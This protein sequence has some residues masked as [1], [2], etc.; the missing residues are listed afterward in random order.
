MVA[1]AEK[2]GDSATATKYRAILEDRNKQSSEQ[3]AQIR[4]NEAHASVQKLTTKLETEK[5]IL[6][7][8]V[9]QVD[10][11]QQLVDNVLTD[12]EKAEEEYRR[13]VRDL[14]AGTG[15]APAGGSDTKQGD[16]KV[17]P[18]FSLAKLM[19]GDLDIQ[20]DDENLFGLGDFED[21]APEALQESQAR[22]Q[23]MLESFKSMAT[24]FFGEVREKGKALTEEHRQLQE[25]LAAKKRKVASPRPT[26]AP[27]AEAAP[28]AAGGHGTGGGGADAGAP[29]TE[30]STQAAA[31]D[32]KQEARA[33]VAAAKGL[34]RGT[35]QEPP[36]S[37]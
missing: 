16:P 37:G 28:S 23:Q 22:K 7:N 26:G 36:S 9:E 34:G 3:P 29:T 32:V 10:I 13:A 12:L 21:L 18:K 1:L 31:A 35:S 15:A 2:S 5:E 33:A 25:R 6:D 4:A 14:A 27:S 24:Q 19:D 17:P 30:A 20:L 11:Q 8:M